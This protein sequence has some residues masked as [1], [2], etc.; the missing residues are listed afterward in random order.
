MIPAILADQLETGVKDFLR[1]TFPISTPLFHGAMES[2]LEKENIF[3]GPYGS[4]QLPFQQGKNEHEY[5]SD[6]KLHFRPYLHQEQAFRRLSG[7]KPASTIIATGTGSGKTECFLYPILDHCY[8]HRGQPGIKAILIYPMNALATDQADR[9]ARTIF[10]DDYLKGNVTAGL[11]IGQSEQEPFSV[12]TR[13]SIIT[14][15]DTMRLSPPDI[16][17]TNY[18][19]LDYLLLR[20]KDSPL[21]KHNKPETLQ[22]LV[23]D[24][25]HTFDGAQGT[26]LAYLIRRLKA[27][28]NTPS[29]HLCCIG[30][31]A[32]IGGR[33][34]SA[35]LTAYAED[36]FGEVFE[37]DAVINET[38]ISAGDFLGRSIVSRTETVSL[39][40]AERLNPEA[41]DDYGEY[42]IGQHLL[43]FNE[44]IHA[45]ALKS[46]QWR[47]D[48]GVK[49]KEHLFFQ[50]L[51]KII[52]SRI[53]PFN[54]LVEELERIMPGL[55]ET[56]PEY[57]VN[58]LSSMLSL[59]SEAKVWASP[60]DS[61][62]DGSLE[63]KS[64]ERSTL[65]FLNI[66]VQLWMRELRRMV[67]L[68][69]SSPR[70][71]F[72]DDLREH[73]LKTCL[74][75]LHCRECGATGWGGLMR[76]LDTKINPDLKSF[77]VAFFEDAPT[78]KYIF[79]EDQGSSDTDLEGIQCWLCSSCLSITVD[80]HQKCPSCGN[81]E[82]IRVFVPHNLTMRNNHQVSSNNCPYCGAHRS[83]TIMGS[84]AASL[85]SVLIAQLY[86]S[87]YNDDKKLITFSDSVQDASHR[88][89]FF[90][91]RTYHFNFRCALQQFVMESGAGM[92]LEDIPEAFIQYWSARKNQKEYIT[93]FLPPNMS[94]FRDYEHLKKNGVLPQGS[95]L[96]E[97]INRRIVW[98]IVSEY[99]FGA[100]I[101]RTLEKTGS[102][103]A[104]LDVEKLDS[105]IPS[106][107]ETLQNEIGELQGLDD[108]TLKRFILGII[109]HLKNIGGVRQAV[110]DEY[111]SKY[112]NSYLITQKHIRWMPN[113]GPRTRTPKFL[114]TK[115][116]N[117]FERLFSAKGNRS[118]W[119]EA[120]ARKCFSDINFL[121]GSMVGAIY[122]PVLK[123]LTD[124]GVLMS[125]T[126]GGHTIWGI[127]PKALVVS[128]G[129]SQF[130]CSK[131]GHVIS[132]ASI[133]KLFWEGAPCQRHHCGGTYTEEAAKRDY[134][135]RLYAR[136]DIERLFPAEH[137]GLLERDERQELEKE[138]KAPAQD[139]EPWYPNLLSCT[140]TLEMGID[141]GDLSSLILCSV[142]PSQSSYLQRI[143]RAGRRD[144]N[145]LNVAVANARPHDLYFYA[146]PQMMIS[147]SV[148]TPGVFL[149]AS[150]VLSRQF[151]AYCFDRW[152]ETGISEN[153]VPPKLGQ[154]LNALDSV[155]NNRFPYNV[156]HYIRTNK[157]DLYDRFVAIFDSGK[158]NL[159]DEA[160]SYLQTFLMGDD[161]AS[162]GLSYVIMDGL[163]NL[164]KERD[165]LRKKIQILRGKISRKQKE[166]AKDLNY[167]QELNELR[168]E[169]S[170]LQAIVAN[171]ND[172]DTF[173]FFTDE[174]LL[175][176]YA[177]PEA[178]VVLKS[179]IYRKREPGEDEQRKYETWA[180]EYERPGARAIYELAPENH[181][182]A[183]GRKVMIDQVDM[184][185]SEIETWRF[186]DQCSHMERVDLNE[187]S[188]CPR[189]GSVMWS[190]AAQKRKMLRMRQV[191]ATTPDRDSRI[192]DDSDDR[193]P[194]FF[195]RQIMV[196]FED[197]AI[198][199]A[200]K[201]DNEDLPFGFEFLSKASFRE[202]NFG[203]KVVNAEEIT[204]AGVTLPRKGFSICSNCG[205]I[206]DDKG[207]IKHAF[208][209]TA[210]DKDSTQNITDCVYI[211]R[212][213]SSEAIRILL[214]V[215][216]FAG[217]DRKLHSFVA[218]FQLG[219]KRKFGGNID[220]LQTTVYEDPVP[221]ST[222]RKKY[223]VLYDTVPGGTGYLKE[224]ML[225]QEPLIEVF[226][227]A[228]N[229]MR[230]CSCNKDP[231]KDGCYKCLYAYRNSYDM[232]ETSRDTAIDLFSRIIQVS[233]SIVKTDTISTI[234]VNPFIESELEARFIDALMSFR[235][236][237]NPILLRK[238]I[239]KGKPGYFIKVNER[240]YFIEL[241][242]PLDSAQGVSI[243]S[244][245][246]FVF[247]PVRKQD[248]VLPI[249]VFT[250]GYQYH[251]DRIGLDMAQRM[252]LSMS[253]NFH[254]WSLTWKDID[255]SNKAKGG[256]FR[257]YMDPAKTLNHTKYL[258]FIRG[259]K[260]DQLSGVHAKDSFALLIDYLGNPDDSLWRTYAFVHS[261]MHVD[262][263]LSGKPD[264]IQIIKQEMDQR[265]PDNLQTVFEELSDPLFGQCKFAEASEIIPVNLV[266][267][268]A[269]QAINPPSDAYGV[270]VVCNLDDRDEVR[271]AEWF[272]QVWNGYLHM[273][274]LMQFIPYSI[275]TTKTGLDAGQYYSLKCKVGKVME[276]EADRS[277]Q[278]WADI[279]EL[280]DAEYHKFLD[281]LSAGGWP[282]PEVGFEFTAGGE[283]IIATA[284]IA[285]IDLKIALLRDDET[286]FE[287]IFLDDNWKVYLL[288]DVMKDAA[289]FVSLYPAR[290]TV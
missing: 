64:T 195:N 169:K 149:R 119:Y 164:R 233:D 111:I 91:A 275:F 13:E 231:E 124:A 148:E 110:L 9:I 194:V 225:S 266:V 136:G 159:P 131:C 256:Y 30:T 264:E 163:H 5:F 52:D 249:A 90:G 61:M 247:W 213:F 17:L 273:Y 31:S 49:L 71:M 278:G 222:F 123:S 63:N 141:I 38:R 45:E 237:G 46:D 68:V 145:A 289:E 165:S 250:D 279:K 28:L 2:L 212:E 263:A 262:N 157:A 192:T 39:D 280:I 185:V 199:S 162:G 154:V 271:K 86:A 106:L 207:N 193:E 47:V 209:C 92:S 265:V 248:G 112:G 127:L 244:K 34:D 125:W 85:T 261:L 114:T 82:L 242:V 259:F 134:Y 252:A 72:A 96:I 286:G 172:R 48:L 115:K 171:I 150:A 284:E 228:L 69:S 254:V 87:H 10:D 276:T 70:F 183:G 285:W 81:E 55:K 179:I 20:P 196:D 84:R 152:V 226:S 6:I 104:H 18:K 33:D 132:A 161:A 16:I 287:K 223:L 175:P 153:A 108:I 19:M 118:T 83:L 166:T 99:G 121:A 8:R 236:S 142:P 146:D 214:P 202:I 54:D 208:T 234:S 197:K 94:W 257:N 78:V 98:E 235:I 12:M 180:F 204:I 76:P 260:A 130:R 155:N 290:R 58:L 107:L 57:R 137:S 126:V 113:F 22:F 220:H 135:G 151:T 210:R 139:R 122:D 253:G 109:M 203:R 201:V 67:S 191:F 42:I 281:T 215:T 43:W 188:T 177:F 75:V 14:N 187:K 186:C 65:P 255:R 32:T 227:L 245:A 189:C 182:Y 211:Y 50:N 120:W 25:L 174:G 26:D 240:A 269:K 200:Y 116:T 21:W 217:S 283:E 277:D 288:A 167:E 102:S 105:L 24:E 44:S 11:Y 268:I 77:Y 270:G 221:D 128:T 178:G 117:N 7:Q 267:Q 73:Q 79:P 1:T 282:V 138:F 176:N 35:K 15:K 243:P 239:V 40:D 27:R 232:A 29:E 205:K 93:T 168:Q 144:G 103:V 41:Y 74:P 241:Q 156:L 23:V 246:D 258:P 170:G 251:R 190:E 173:N 181:F 66:R 95:R 198:T 80:A 59:V 62:P 3:K 274:N 158:T 184:N 147:G 60:N 37:R 53:V 216:T 56:A 4:I 230:A 88:A 129:V 238:D 97:D 140:P 51:V 219:L 206:Q 143:G 101:G 272:E 229:A 160:K 89:G 218:G 100:R 133:E 224:L 36:V